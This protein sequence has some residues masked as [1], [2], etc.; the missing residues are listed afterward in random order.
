MTDATP[1]KV[2][3]APGLRCPACASLDLECRH[4]R[5]GVNR[6]IRV[7]KCRSCGHTFRTAERVENTNLGDER[8]P[9]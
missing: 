9:A 5:H 6:K 2:L 1:P 4:T 7:R 8:R 3:S